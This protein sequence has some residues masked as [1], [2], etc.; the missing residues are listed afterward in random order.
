MVVAAAAFARARLDTRPRA[1]RV[2]GMLAGVEIAVIVL[3]LA[4]LVVIGATQIVL[5]NVAHTGL[6]WA[7]PLMRHAVLWL[8]A[9]GASLATSRMR[10][11]NIDVFSRLLPEP[12]RPLRRVVVYLATA[13]AAW[14]LAVSTARLVVDER[15]F[16]DVA[17][18]GVHTWV[19][20]LVLPC[21]FTLIAYRS[22]VNLFLG[23][24]GDIA[25]GEGE[26]PV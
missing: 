24:E 8:G 3:L 1:R 22:L 6:L 17:F 5:R 21:A 18:L 4:A 16:G 12:L 13:A 10:H 14:V 7:D 20:Q 11:I 2:F 25:T 23:R 19:M 9:L 26:F 15:A